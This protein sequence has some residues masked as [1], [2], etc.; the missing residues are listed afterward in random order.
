MNSADC[1]HIAI[2]TAAALSA[3]AA[4]SGMLVIG[5][6]WT[7]ISSCQ[8]SSGFDPKP[9][10]ADLQVM[11]TALATRYA[12]LEWAVHDHGADL[13]EYFARARKRIETADD[14]GSA[15][16]AFDGLI[17][18]LG[19]GHVEIDWPA[20]SSTPAAAQ[21]TCAAIGYDASKS[22]PPLA[23]LASN[24]RPLTTKNAP[25]FPAGIIAV[26]QHHLGVIKIGLFSPQ[27]SPTLCPATLAALSV[28]LHAPCDDKCAERVDRLAHARMTRDF[29]TQ[30][31]ALKSAGADTLLVD[32][33]G[34]G[35]GSEWAEAAARMVTAV[36]LHSERLA[37]VRG[38][39][40]A[41]E[42]AALEKDLQTAARS[43]QP[44][45]RRSLLQLA[46]SAAEKRVDATRRCDSAPLWKGSRLSCAWLGDGF[47]ASGLLASADPK[48]LWG[49]PWAASVFT[50][51]E[52]P[53]EEGVWTG[54][55]VVLVDGETWSAAEE[56]AAVLQDNHAALV[57]GEPTGGAGCGHTDGAAP[58]LLP[59]SGGTLE[60]PDCARL[61]A[62][63]SNEVRGI[64]PDISLRWGR[65]DGP[66]RRAQVLAQQ[67]SMIVETAQRQTQD[68][69][70]GQPR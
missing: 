17:R 54:P 70:R 16:A 23:G 42:F 40:W 65:H 35:G 62:D 36:R 5:A 49:K 33:T 10:L 25:E 24:Y 4:L 43:A 48:S 30:L 46:Q 1:L 61:R 58:V 20:R 55:L 29:I 50:P 28:P 6:V 56:F 39:Q 27:G 68:A 11:R 59:H 31:G 22:A 53:Y 64:T 2:R 21:D 12:N 32:I 15:R 13:N 9:W 51:M 41:D 8:A 34:N 57:V 3:R 47:Y 67:L 14:A 7:G 38:K 69:K 26:G 66:A 60:L 63:G 45:D 44:Q 52:Y 37:F 19:D 18:R